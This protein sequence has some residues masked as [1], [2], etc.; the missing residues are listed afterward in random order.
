MVGDF[1]VCVDRI[2]ASACF[3]PT[4]GLSGAAATVKTGTAGVEEGSSENKKGVQQQVKKKK[5]GGGEAIECRICQEEGE[6]GEM[7]SPCACNGTLKFAHRKCIQRW[8][9]KKGDITCEICNQVYTPNYSIPPNRATSDVM[10]IDIR[11]NWAAGID[12]NDPRYLA[13]AAAEQE[14]LRA[15]YENYAAASSSGISCCRT[16]A[17]LLMLLLLVRH[18]LMVV[19]DSG[20][21]QDISSFFNVTLLQFLV[22]LLPCYVIARACY[23]LQSRRRRQV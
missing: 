7:E 20:M 4:N 17:L 6:E 15:E 14:F 22:F 8:C 3:D 19:V 9:N 21:V 10:A 18:V 12:L 16:V 11:Q 5:K 13:I 23:I 1:M 2:I